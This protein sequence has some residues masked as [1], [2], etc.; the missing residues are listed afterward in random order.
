MPVFTIE[1]PTGRR[2]KIEAP[3]QATAMR[4]AEEWEASQAK[5]A[6]TT[7]QP[8]PPDQYR[9]A[10]MEEIEKAKAGGFHQTGGYTRRALQGAT[11]GAADEILAGLMTPFEMAKRGTFNPAEGYNYAKAREDL[12]LEE[13][14]ANQ[15]M[16]GT[17]AEIGGGFM[18]GSALSRAGAT[19]MPTAPGASLARRA[20][21]AL[22]DG[23][24]YG[25]AS[26]FAEGS[27][28]EDRLQGAATGAAIGGALGGAIP[29]AGAAL[30]GP[31]SAVRAM[32][33]P[34]GVAD[35]Q[36][37]RA[38]GESGRSAD[39][40]ANAVRQ[41]AQEG[42]GVYTVADELGNAGQRMLGTVTRAPGAGRQAATEFLDARQAGQGRRLA[43]TLDE[44]FGSSQTARQLQT[45]QETAR[46]AE[47]DALYGAA[48][49]A[50]GAVDLSRPLAMMDDVLRPGVN[51]VVNPGSGIAD[52][53]VEGAV[54][55]AQRFLTDGRSVLSDFDS[56]LRAKQE[57][58]SIIDRASP[59][60]MRVLIPIRNEV[61][62]ALEAASAPYAQA[63]N[64]YREASQGIE[65]IQTG[66]QASQRGRFEDT[67]P[68]YQ[69][70]A[71]RQQ[72]G[73][74]TGYADNL[75]EG[76]QGSA[77]GVNKAR[78]FTTDAARAELPAFAAPGQADLMN[79]RIGRENTMFRTRAEAT[80]GSKT[81]DNLQDMEGMRVDPSIFGN[82][83][84]GRPMAAASSAANQFISNLSGYTPA[85]REE[86]GQLLLMRGMDPQVVQSLQRAMD[87]STRARQTVARF[88][89]G[90]MGAAAV[91]SN[92]LPQNGSPSR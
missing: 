44:G 39:D 28:M 26:G 8:E 25:A 75:I 21:G 18:S 9:A 34:R 68:A 52:D 2:L 55:R 5:Q 88:L 22:A 77:E 85:V 32:V 66:R 71:P 58:D 47:G 65:A 45:A 90:G 6:A 54:R 87:R 43:N 20:G 41:A 51:R 19:F 46:R 56:V 74:R 91:S 62:R 60:Q 70:M 7:A 16:L 31:A 57:I 12:Q 33:D 14:R 63:R 92:A 50:A 10:A 61:D 67:I 4:G 13:M 48:R 64:A 27:G 80:G 81:A 11:F 36:L 72:E 40:V 78:Q 17:A 23:L 35:S 15:G 38:I 3:D 24:A 89:A 76:I 29:L 30:S 1:T 82:L 86:L 37:A 73:F 83:I 42:Q 79:R 84:A 69:G 53:S 59:T 49:D